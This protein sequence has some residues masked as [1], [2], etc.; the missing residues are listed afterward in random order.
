MC[1][2]GGFNLH[3]FL[4]NSK[5]VIKNVP[6]NDRAEGVKEIDLD[7]DKLPLERTLGVQ[8]CVKSDSFEFNIILQDKPCMRRGILSTVSSVYDPIGF[9]A[10]LMLQ[11]K[12]ILQDLCGLSLDWDDPVPD[13]VKMKWEKWRM[14]VMK[15]RSIK[16][17]RCYKPNPFGRVVRAE[18]HHFSGASIQGY[19]QCSYLRLEDEK[20]N[21]HC[22]FVMGKSRVAPLKPVTI[23]RLELTAAVCSVRISQQIHRELE[24]RIDEDFYWTDSKVVLGH[25]SNESKHFHVY[26]SNRVQEIQDNTDKKQWRY[27]E[28]KQNPA[29]EASRGMKAKELQDSR[30]IV[31]LEFLWRKECK[32]RNSVEQNH[33]LQEEDPE[34]KRSVTMAT[35]SS[36]G[37]KSTLDERVQLFSS[38]YHSQRAVASCMKYIKKLKARAKKEPDQTAELKAQDLERAGKLIIRA[39]QFKAFQDQLK[40][41][42][43]KEEDTPRHKTS[44]TRSSILPLDP[45]IDEDGILRAGG[46]LK[47]AN[48][49]SQVKHPIILSK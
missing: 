39:A 30:W 19:G 23:P 36:D 26:V 2:Q 46:R 18:L 34:V 1:H 43:D 14:E 47:N 37:P 8:L 13:D 33:I 21:V 22:E 25:L 49:S 5:E 3:K 32:W 29:D 27:I 40:K 48:L 41:L 12:S 42:R 20:H 35:W 38:W 16:I 44:R 10:P 9:L 17:P 45:F 15:L 24:Y 6:E 4:S 28:S 11:G 31:G 7:L